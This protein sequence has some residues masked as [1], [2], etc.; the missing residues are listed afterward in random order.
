[1][2][3]GLRIA[4][5]LLGI[6]ILGQLIYVCV[7]GFRDYTGTADIAIVLGNRVNADSTLSPVLKGRVDR[8]LELYRDRKVARI[9]VSG[10]LGKGEGMG[11]V[12]EGMAMK[13]YLVAHGVPADKVIEDNEGENTYLTAKD[14]LPVA[15]SLHLHS[16]IAVSSFYHLTRTKYI[17]RHVGFTNVHSVASRALFWNDLLGLPRD[18]VAFYKYLLVY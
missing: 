12:P 2:R 7:D 1:M 4:G 15:D 8:A 9:M 5:L 11:G 14:F 6:W 3:K 17:L 16:A 18:C 10:G 13:R